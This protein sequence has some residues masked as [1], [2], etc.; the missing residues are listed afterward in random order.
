VR[1]LSFRGFHV[2]CVVASLAVTS[3][4]AYSQTPAATLLPTE[5]RLPTHF[6]TNQSWRNDSPTHYLTASGKFRG[7]GVT[8]T[9]LI[10]VRKD[11]SGFAPFIA[12]GGNRNSVKFL[13]GEKTNEIQYLASEGLKIATRGTYRTACGKGYGCDPGELKSITLEN[14]AIEFFKSEGPSR[15]I[16]WDKANNRF[17]EVWLSD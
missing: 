12:L 4:V 10:L 16:Y 7:G 8:D 13:Q 9:A 15:L 2:A 3:V 17:A 5:W 14:D 6:E 11:R 1:F